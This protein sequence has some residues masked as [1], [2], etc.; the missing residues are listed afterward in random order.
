MTEGKRL[1]PL[2]SGVPE[3]VKDLD[4]HSTEVTKR[5]IIPSTRHIGM[6]KP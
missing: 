1:A 4:K 3:K 2:S 6:C 5:E